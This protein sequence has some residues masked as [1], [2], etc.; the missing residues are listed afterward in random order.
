VILVLLAVDK[1]GSIVDRETHAPQPYILG[2]RSSRLVRVV[3][4]PWCW[5]GLLLTVR[6]FMAA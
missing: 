1:L 3:A 5:A 4:A 6:G 2:L